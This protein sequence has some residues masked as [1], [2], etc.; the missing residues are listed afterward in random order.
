MT[1]R[2]CGDARDFLAFGT[3]CMKAALSDAR[4][5]IKD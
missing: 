1:I 4:M 3:N 5:A 2:S